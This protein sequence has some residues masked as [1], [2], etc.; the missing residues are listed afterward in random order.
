M[1][2]FDAHVFH[3]LQV[4]GKAQGP[5]PKRWQYRRTCC[6]RGSRSNKIKRRVCRRASQCIRHISRPMHQS[7]LW[8]V[9]PECIKHFPCCDCR[10]QGQ[11]TAGERLRQCDDV[12]HYARLFARKHRA[13]A[14]KA[15]EYFI[16]DQD[17]FVAV[18]R[19]AKQPQ[20]F[21]VAEDHAASALHQR[22][23]DDPRIFRREALEKMA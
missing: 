9:R 3:T 5:A 17:L 7:L 15:G 23:D 4:D 12:G 13:G 19:F 2:P 21:F 16:E 18:G 6:S 11:R 1:A 14:A 10:R 20:Q 22:L 8:I